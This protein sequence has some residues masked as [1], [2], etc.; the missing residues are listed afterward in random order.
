M[1][2]IFLYN[3]WNEMAIADGGNG[4][5]PNQTIKTM[6]EELA[7]LLW[8][9]TKAED[10]VI[11]NQKPDLEW[12]SR[13][14]SQISSIPK[15]HTLNETTEKIR[16]Q[17]FPIDNIE[18]WGWSPRLLK[19]LESL[20]PHVPKPKINSPNYRWNSAYKDFYGRKT[21]LK[22]LSLFLKSYPE[23]RKMFIPDEHIPEIV[24]HIHDIQALLKRWNK[25]VVKAPHSSSGRGI[26]PITHHELNQ[27]I[28][29][30][31]QQSI[32]QSGYAMCEPYLDVVA[33]I[34]LQFQIDSENCRP[35]SIQ[36]F[37]SS[38]KGNYVGNYVGKFP[39]THQSK[40]FLS[41]IDWNDFSNKLATIL[42][43]I[44]TQNYYHGFFGIDTLLYK[45]SNGE[46][47]LN[48]CSEINLRKNMGL[49]AQQIAQHIDT[50]AGLYGFLRI[51]NRNN[52]EHSRYFNE[53][54]RSFENTFLLNQPGLFPI[55]PYKNNSYCLVVEIQQD[56]YNQPMFTL[57]KFSS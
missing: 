14:R 16:K 40:E 3:P 46:L 6:A 36:A 47:K 5:L 10:I 18:P 12:I 39:V 29:Q 11:V 24:Y 42:W 37:E 30:R 9:F 8:V 15:F 34:S 55:T 13:L 28:L 26:L 25:I 53:L 52:P 22:V 21:A 43:K 31:I 7:P 38:P 4:F 41:K 2:A 44:N 27:N 50:K 35:V 1:P 57:Q 54:D 45:T 33:Q 17:E 56:N 20:L 32:N 23:N 19:I 48:P 49:V 51:I